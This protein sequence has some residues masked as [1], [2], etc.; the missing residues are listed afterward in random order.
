[1]PST[2]RRGLCRFCASGKAPHYNPLKMGWR[3]ARRCLLLG[4]MLTGVM[5][6]VTAATHA[7]PPGL[8]GD[9]RLA[10]VL[11]G[12]QNRLLTAWF[13]A[14]GPPRPQEAFGALVAR[15]ARLELGKPYYDEPWH[16]GPE[17]LESRVDSFQC[18]S[19]VESSL[20]LA[21][22]VWR[23][24]ST[25]LCFLHEVQR[26]RYR[27]GEVEGYPSR[28][29]YFEDWLSDNAQR[30]HL[31]L[32]TRNLGGQPVTLNYS[33]M[34]S[35]PAKFPAL[36]DADIRTAISA[37]EARLS[38]TKM[39]VLDRDKILATERA[40]QSGDIIAVA[41]RVGGMMV[42]H[43]GL[44]YLDDAHVAHLLHA[45]SA[46]HHVVLSKEDLS[47]YIL[48]RP[49]RRGILVAR[50]VAPSSLADAQ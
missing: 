4:L 2:V 16:P 50:P 8:P 10:R 31:N 32:L 5:R 28:L 34:S 36:E 40:L 38:H 47:E 26:L 3:V 30:G 15:A 35:H 11:D 27:H 29:H 6:Q 9:A 49:E 23:N 20:A 46:Q 33:Y 43:T 24:N 45:S 21:R 13:R 41:S 37:T 44:V 12:A 17:A 19:L 7:P 18:V 39:Y 25:S 22:C 42:T 48:R 1:M 14:V